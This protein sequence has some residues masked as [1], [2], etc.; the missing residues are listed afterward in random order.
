[1]FFNLLDDDSY[2][3]VVTEPEVAAELEEAFVDPETASKLDSA[4][5]SAFQTGNFENLVQIINADPQF[6]DYKVLPT[7][8]VEGVFPKRHSLFPHCFQI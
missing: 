5:A 4:I 8:F 7:A 2:L 1:M 6:A 3:D